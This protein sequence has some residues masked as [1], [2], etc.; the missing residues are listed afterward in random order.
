MDKSCH[1]YEYVKESCHR[2]TR[3]W[4]VFWER[5]CGNEMWLLAMRW[6]WDVT[7]LSCEKGTHGILIEMWLFYVRRYPF[8]WVASHLIAASP[9]SADTPL[10]AMRWQWDVTHISHLTSHVKTRHHI[11]WQCEDSW[12]WDGN[13]MAMRCGNE[14]MR[15]EWDV[16]HILLPMR[17]WLTS[18]VAIRWQWDCKWDVTL[19]MWMAMRCGKEMRQCE[20]T[21]AHCRCGKWDVTLGN[22]MAMRWQWDVTHISLPMRQWCPKLQIIFHKRA[23]KSSHCNVKTRHLIADVAMRC[24]S[25]MS[26]VTHSYESCRAYKWVLAKPHKEY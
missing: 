7:H 11:A 1:T 25:F 2:H 12:Q 26:A 10:P 14:A 8:V 13:E 5:G 4:R 3:K 24:D 15:W 23:T 6:Q 22:E 18:D 21:P 9:L 16:T 17:P 20:D 19:E